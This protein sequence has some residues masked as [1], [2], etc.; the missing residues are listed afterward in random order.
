M[1]YWDASKTV[2]SKNVETNSLGTVFEY[3][4]CL[5]TDAQRV[6]ADV[7]RD[8]PTAQFSDPTVQE[9]SGYEYVEAQ[10]DKRRP[11]I[12]NSPTMPSVYPSQLLTN[13]SAFPGASGM[14]ALPDPTTGGSLPRRIARPSAPVAAKP[15]PTPD[16]I[17][18]IMLL[19]QQ[20]LALKT[21]F[22]MV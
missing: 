5:L 8:I 1:G 7:N 6:I 16:D 18:Q 17:K 9:L 3:T 20:L 15:T 22:G 2:F 13:E 4:L 19:E 21:K 12:S 14:W 10:P 11:Y